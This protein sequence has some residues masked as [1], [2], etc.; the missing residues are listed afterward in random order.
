MLEKKGSN[1][2]IPEIILVVFVVSFTFEE[3][4]Q[5]TF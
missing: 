1:P 5:V 2:E 4:N 3:T